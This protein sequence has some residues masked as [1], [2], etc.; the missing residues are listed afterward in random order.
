M[1]LRQGMCTDTKQKTMCKPL[2]SSSPTCESFNLQ[3]QTMKGH[4]F[5]SADWLMSRQSQI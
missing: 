3:V 1:C 4:V 2:P 5:L